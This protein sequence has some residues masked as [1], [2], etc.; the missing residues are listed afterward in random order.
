ML[1]LL[2]AMMARTE[3]QPQLE[4]KPARGRAPLSGKAVAALCVTSFVV[5]LLLSGNVSLMS[6]SASPSS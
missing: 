4:R 3:R 1:Q 6:A 2:R 5:W